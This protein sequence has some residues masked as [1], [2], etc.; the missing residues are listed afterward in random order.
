M[1][2]EHRVSALEKTVAQLTKNGVPNDEGHFSGFF[3]AAEVI[4][5]MAGGLALIAACTFLGVWAATA[6]IRVFKN[7]PEWRDYFFGDQGNS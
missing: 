2:L 3:Q 7:N 6:L 4:L 5:S 1:S